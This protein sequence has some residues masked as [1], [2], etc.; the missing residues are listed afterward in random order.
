MSTLFFYT[1]QQFINFKS[2]QTAAGIEFLSMSKLLSSQRIDELDEYQQYYVDISSMVGF[3]KNNDSQL[4]NFEQL[5]VSFGGNITFICDKV[6]E[7]K[8]K[9]H[10]PRD[11]FWHFYNTIGHEI[12]STEYLKQLIQ[13]KN[14]FGYVLKDINGKIHQLIGLK[15]KMAVHFV[16]IIKCYQVIMI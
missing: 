15:D 3:V 1:R 6:Y 4:L 2:A 13:I 7:K 8:T 16:Q 11:L 14:D 12:D 5:F 10:H 9:Y